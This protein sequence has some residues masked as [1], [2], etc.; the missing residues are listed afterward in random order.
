VLIRR[1]HRIRLAIAGA[2]KDTFRRLPE[3]GDPVLTV[4]RS[5]THAS[6]VELPLV[7]RP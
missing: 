6:Y 2:D 4:G 3:S 7:P 1:G 5:R